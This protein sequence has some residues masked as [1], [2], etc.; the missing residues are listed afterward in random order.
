MT[1]LNELRFDEYCAK[2]KVIRTQEHHNE[3]YL[4]EYIEP[5]WFCDTC[6]VKLFDYLRPRRTRAIKGFLKD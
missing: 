5:L 6:W 3:G 4:W 2:C 1:N